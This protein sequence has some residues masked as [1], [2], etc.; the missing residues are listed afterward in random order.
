[1][2]L[3]EWN[4][5]QDTLSTDSK[6]LMPTCGDWRRLSKLTGETNIESVKLG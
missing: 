1:M 4:H 3:V 2:L 6:K 5:R